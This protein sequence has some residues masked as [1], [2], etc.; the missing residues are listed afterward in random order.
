[1]PDKPAGPSIL[2]VDDDPSVQA[3]VSDFL[4]AN[5]YRVHVAADG[6]GMRR[7]LDRHEIAVVLLDVML[8]GDDG[9][10]L[11]RELRDI[12]DIGI[13]MLS[14]RGSEADRVSGLEMG[15]DDYL[16]KPA[17]PRELLA[18]IRA[19]Q[20]RYQG[21]R[22]GR[23]QGTGFSFEGWT[24]D[25]VRRVL[26]DRAGLVVS[27][28]EGE[29]ELLLAFVENPGQVLSRDQLLEL[30]RGEESEAFDRAVDVQV[31]R[32]RRK[33]GQCLN[34]EAIRTVRGEGYLFAPVV[35]RS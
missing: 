17:A 24:F 20:R 33:L 15:A 35:G 29:F 2:I 16:P 13:I 7:V 21:D 25:P 12:G 23:V 31:S 18:R 32:L 4:T 28:S 1:M 8:P 14:A 27:L 26:R 6:P 30:A 22:A 34:G 11:A 10:A 19:V 5:G 9:L 3:A